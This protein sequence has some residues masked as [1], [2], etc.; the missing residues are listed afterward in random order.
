VLVTFAGV[1]LMALDPLPCILLGVALLTV[2][3]FAA[4]SVASSWVGRR[5]RVAHAQASA[6]YLIPR[7]PSRCGCARR[8]RLRH[9]ATRPRPE[10]MPSRR[11]R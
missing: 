6:L 5:A 4:H 7:S 3:F 10:R 8:H 2:G 11:E 9:R 1:A